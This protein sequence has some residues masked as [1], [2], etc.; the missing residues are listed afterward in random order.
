MTLSQLNKLLSGLDTL[1][2]KVLNRTSVIAVRIHWDPTDLHLQAQTQ[3]HL[4]DDLESY[5]DKTCMSSL[6]PL[7]QAALKPSNVASTTSQQYKVLYKNHNIQV[8]LLSKTKAF[9]P[10]FNKQGPH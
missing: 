7:S 8:L 3:G 5:L 10:H 1:S 4:R 6:I 9:L 2:F